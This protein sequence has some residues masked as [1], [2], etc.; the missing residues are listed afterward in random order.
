MRAN[1]LLD[2]NNSEP[3]LSDPKEM[4]TY[5]EEKDQIGEENYIFQEN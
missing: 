2:I 5:V 4:S 1:I 3:D